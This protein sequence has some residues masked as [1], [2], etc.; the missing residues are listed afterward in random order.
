MEGKT[1][2]IRLHYAGTPGEGYGWGV[3]NRNLLRELETRAWLVHWD[4]EPGA[5]FM[6]LCDHDFNPLTP[7]RGKINLAYTFFEFPL[8]PNAAANAAK[9]D[10]V[11]CGS[12]WCLNRMREA[13]ITNG[14]VLIQGV[15]HEIFHPAPPRP[16]SSSFRIFS[17]GKFEWRKGQ[18]LVIAAFKEFSR[19]HPEAHLV[20]AWH[21]PWPAL[22]ESMRQS[23]FIR[24]ST[25]DVQRS[26]FSPSTYNQEILFKELMFENGLQHFTIL[27]QLSQHDLANEMR[28][29]DVGLFPNRC[30]GGTNLVLM[31]YLACGKPAVANLLTGHYDIHRDI[32][33]YI[34]AREDEMHWAIQSVDDIVAALESAYFDVQRSTFN[35]R[36]FKWSK[37]A[38]QIIARAE[39]LL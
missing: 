6:P 29:T 30:E 10:V 3:C 33:I 19:A 38:E 28:N 20:C 36:R 37:P 15:D 4:N 21:N 23:P 24:R 18:D 17:G 16:S 26:R 8:G 9:Y 1:D 34:P 7:A 39:S 12:T 35:V 32:D 5:V 31:E 27:P 13:G 14:E 2:M 25:F 22:I 11:F